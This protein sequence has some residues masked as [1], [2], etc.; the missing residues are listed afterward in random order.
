LVAGRGGVVA[1]AAP[2]VGRHRLA[3]RATRGSHVS[4][5]IF[6]E[7]SGRLHVV[8]F[9]GAPLDVAALLRPQREPAFDADERR[10]RQAHHPRRDTR[11]L[12][13]R[14]GFA[15]PP[16]IAVASDAPRKLAL[17]RSLAR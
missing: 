9:G 5:N 6:A 17:L 7:S 16:H 15:R 11:V 1:S 2:L 3:V 12:A 13:P 8:G 14:D 4:P 10:A